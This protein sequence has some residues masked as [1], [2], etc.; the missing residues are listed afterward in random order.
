M[1]LLHS[2]YDFSMEILPIGMGQFSRCVRSSGVDIGNAFDSI[3]ETLYNLPGAR[4]GKYLFSLVNVFCSH[5]NTSYGL[6]DP[7]PEEVLP[8][9]CTWYYTF[10]LRAAWY[11]SEF[12]VGVNSL[13]SISARAWG[14]K[15]IEFLTIGVSHMDSQAL[16]LRYDLFTPQT[17]YY[18]LGALSKSFMLSSKFRTVADDYEEFY[19]KDFSMLYVQHYMRPLYSTLRDAAIPHYVFNRHVWNTGAKFLT[20]RHITVTTLLYFCQYI[21]QVGVLAQNVQDKIVD[22]FHESLTDLVQRRDRQEVPSEAYQVLYAALVNKGSIENTDI[23]A[24]ANLEQ[25]IVLPTSD[26][27]AHILKLIYS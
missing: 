22:K 14:H 8:K 7:P 15:R 4:A 17:V 27:K 1:K 12:D 23:A 2:D 11:D 16:G 10:A 25:E 9:A 3:S 6:L 13:T 5:T 24:L 21:R 19:R 26:Y 20:P 18:L